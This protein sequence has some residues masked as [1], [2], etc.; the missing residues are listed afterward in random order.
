MTPYRVAILEAARALRRRLVI[1]GGL[2]LLM[3]GAIWIGA[4][5]WSA[6][7]IIRCIE[8]KQVPGQAF[9][10]PT[11][12]D[13]HAVSPYYGIVTSLIGL[14][15]FGLL[16]AG[17]FLLG[18]TLGRGRRPPKKLFWTLILFPW[19]V[20]IPAIL[21]MV[22]APPLLLWMA[23][24]GIATSTWVGLLLLLLVAVS[25]SSHGIERFSR[26]MPPIPA[27]YVPH[28]AKR[29]V[30]DCQS[31]LEKF[32]TMALGYFSCSR[33][34]SAVVHRWVTPDLTG[35]IQ[36]TQQ[37]IGDHW[38]THT[39]L[40]GVISSGHFISVTSSNDAIRIQRPQQET[41]R[42]RPDST[43]EELYAEFTGLMTQMCSR[44][45][46][47]PMQISPREQD[48]LADYGAAYVSDR[49]GLPAVNLTWLANPFLG[50]DPPPIPGNPLVGMER[51]NKTASREQDERQGRDRS[52]VLR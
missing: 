43:I 16:F 34:A 25:T 4:A 22:S 6:S 23:G 19:M 44:Y 28:A 48:D 13:V 45:D 21:S 42:S 51:E 10:G 5:I 17:L 47:V 27:T 52:A 36:A 35:H 24:V 46:A 14:F 11:L 29:S 39:T 40:A 33:D 3:S 9:Q 7:E 37:R 32:G 1:R 20:S 50:S 8:L 31:I 49:P 38:K 30:A 41:V 18:K 12:A 26:P 15:G 2:F